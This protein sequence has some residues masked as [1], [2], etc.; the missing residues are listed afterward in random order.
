MLWQN[1]GVNMKTIYA[2]VKSEYTEQRYFRKARRFCNRNKI[3]IRKISEQGK[4][5]IY[6][7]AEEWQ[8]VKDYLDGKK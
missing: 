7:T 2:W 5:G 8:R 1:N 4:A 6:I 3:G